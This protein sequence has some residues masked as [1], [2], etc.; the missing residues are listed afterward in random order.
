SVIK[1][2]D[3]SGNV[4]STTK[5][6]PFGEV[7]TST[8][9]N[10]SPWGF[11]GTL[12]YFKDTLT[13][14]YVRARTYRA[15]LSRWVTVDPLWPFQPAFI[16]VEALPTVYMDPSGLAPSF[17]GE[18]NCFPTCNERYTC[19]M[20]DVKDLIDPFLNILYVM[21]GVIAGACVLLCFGSAF[22]PKGCAICLIAVAALVALIALLMW[23]RN[24]RKE[25]C[26][27]AYLYCLGILKD[28]PT[29][30]VRPKPVYEPNPWGSSGRINPAL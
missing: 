25:A 16:Y 22:N 21:L 30:V 24:F 12:G 13:R 1:T 26:R 15:D 7:R 11:V 18:C 27:N 3:A 28:D 14:L 29:P 10:P 2:T 8:G 6:W 19:C 4:T 5:Y 17:G 23:I 9:T 20:D